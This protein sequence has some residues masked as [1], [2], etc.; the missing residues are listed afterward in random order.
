MKMTQLS[1]SDLTVSQLAFGCWG[2]TTDMHWGPRDDNESVQAIHAALDAGV[3]FF[4]T[5]EAYGNGE[6]ESLVGKAL[7]NRRNKV[8]IAS[9][10]IPSSMKPD[11]IMAACEGSLVRMGTDYLDLYQLHW[12]DPE[13][14]VS[15]SWGA[16]V[17]LKEQG[18]VR[19]I[20]VCNFGVGHLAEIETTDRP[21]SNQLPYNLIWRAVEHAILPKCISENIS[22]LA[23]SPLMHG[24]LGERYQ[25]A[26]DVPDGRARSRHFSSERSLTRHGE[27]GCEAATFA[28]IDAVRQIAKS[29]GRSTTDVALQWVVAQQG[30]TCVIAGAKSSE[31]V[32]ANVSTLSNP[33]PADAIEEL[34]QATESLKH[35]LGPNPDMWQ[36]LESSRYR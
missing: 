32:K 26:A 18:K 5:A 2:V 36:G 28:A 10:V 8:V 22:V 34:N 3:N 11:Q 7:A 13:V 21:I 30:I 4:D 1:G 20:G 31:Q 23:Y 24:L 12:I 25:V 14:P 17:K 19:E 9:K 15:D 6:S 27:V 33:L 16:L 35:T 29:L